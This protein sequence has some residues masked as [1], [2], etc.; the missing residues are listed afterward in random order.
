MNFQPKNSRYKEAIEE[1]LQRQNFMKHIGFSLD[2][3]SPGYME[4]SLPF[5]DFL[6][7]QVGFLHG[8]AI[9]TLADLVCGFAAYSLVPENEY[10]VT[11]DLK[12]SYLNPGTG[13][14]F[15]AKGWVIKAGSRML[16]CEAEI[17][18]TDSNL[19]IAKASATMVIVPKQIQK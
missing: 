6:K 10:V 11:S 8:G 16:F 2:K 1:V 7:Q 3:I 18:D 12:I 14:I 19:L 17:I 9:A 4:G 15:I 13:K 5:T